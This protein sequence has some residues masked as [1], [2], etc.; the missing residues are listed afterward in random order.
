MLLSRR[1]VGRRT[2]RGRLYVPLPE[3]APWPE[4]DA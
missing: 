1:S 4:E 3:K 2:L